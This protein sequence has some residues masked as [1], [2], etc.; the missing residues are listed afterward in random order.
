MSAL[1]RRLSI[2][3]SAATLTNVCAIIY[4]KDSITCQAAFCPVAQQSLRIYRPRRQWWVAIAI[5]IMELGLC[6][7]RPSLKAI[8]FSTYPG[9]SDLIFCGQECLGE[10]AAAAAAVA[11]NIGYTTDDCLRNHQELAMAYVQS[12]ATSR[13]SRVATDIASATLVMSGT[14]KTIRPWWSHR[15]ACCT[16]ATGASPGSAQATGTI[17][18]RR[19]R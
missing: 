10:I 15:Q 4:L 11:N 9:Y 2:T 18:L 14:A 12:C 7:R 8:S 1:R 16:T 19:T 6:Q 17:F 13:C 5:N 3:I